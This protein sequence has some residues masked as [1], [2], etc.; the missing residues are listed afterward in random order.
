[1]KI[2]INSTAIFPVLYQSKTLSITL[3]EKHRLSVFTNSVLR[4]EFEPNRNEVTR[5]W[6][7]LHNEE[8]YNL[9]CSP[10][11]SRMIESK[12]LNGRGLWHIGG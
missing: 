10:S 8:L 12:E 3:R 1:M 11:F 5:E 2:K 9:C 6:R 4:K 7:K